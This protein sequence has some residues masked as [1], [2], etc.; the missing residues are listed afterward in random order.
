MAR[1][2]KVRHVDS[3]ILDLVEVEAQ[4]RE[5][6]R[7]PDLVQRLHEL[8]C[9]HQ[10]AVDAMILAEEANALIKLSA[11]ELRLIRVVGNA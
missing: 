1:G 8:M 11:E 5:E 3:V 6:G 2:N 4:I 10:F 9:E 7:L